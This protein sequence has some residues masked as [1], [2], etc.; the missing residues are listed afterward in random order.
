MSVEETAE[1]LPRLLYF[2]N[3]FLVGGAP[4]GHPMGEATVGA[5]SDA[6]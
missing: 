6:R 1:V 2:G 5:S 4:A 3:K